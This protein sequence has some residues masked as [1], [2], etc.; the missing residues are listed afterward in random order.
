MPKHT[1][2]TPITNTPGQNN[3]FRR[4]T[5]RF[6]N[7]RCSF[8]AIECVIYNNFYRMESISATNSS[9]YEIYFIYT[10][11]F[12][13]VPLSYTQNFL[14]FVLIGNLNRFKLRNEFFGII[15][16]I[17]VFEQFILN[18]FTHKE[19]HIYNFQ[20]FALVIIVKKLQKIPHS[21]DVQSLTNFYQRARSNLEKYIFFGPLFLP[22]KMKTKAKSSVA[23]YNM[24]VTHFSKGSGQ[25]SR[26]RCTKLLFENSERPPLSDGFSCV[27][28]F[29]KH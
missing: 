6:T 17:S 2:H 16:C 10:S 15:D 24:Q 14:I 4:N 28:H 3:P 22:E 25:L 13:L 26:L 12:H 29:S 23:T 11:L 5:N 27:S 9:K 1:N 20:E 8:D 7:N 21:I 18:I 19:A